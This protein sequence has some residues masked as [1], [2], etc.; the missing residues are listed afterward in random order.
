MT[1]RTLLGHVR[2]PVK[3]LLAK[4][5]I[6]IEFCLRCGVRQP[7]DWWS[8]DALWMDVVGDP[9]GI[10]CPRCFDK[11][12][13]RVGYRLRWAPRMDGWTKP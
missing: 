11:L 4:I 5:T 8:D 1:T 6:V 12:A 13:K 9:Y 7:L 2:I 10:V 3:T